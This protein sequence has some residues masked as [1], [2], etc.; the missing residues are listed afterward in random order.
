MTIEPIDNV[1][2][3]DLGDEVIILDPN[4][5]SFNDATLDKFNENLSL[6]YDYFSSKS[7][8]A[9]SIQ[10]I[11][12]MDY[13]TIYFTKFAEAKAEGI[14]DKGADAMAKVSPTVIEANKSAINAKYN[15]RQIKEYL[16]AYDKTHDMAKARQYQ[17]GKE[18]D[19]FGS[20][21]YYKKE[22]NVDDILSSND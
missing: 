7:A 10:A 21:N 5:L 16:K 19:K 1:R 12:E 17:R 20:D 6:Y 4:L 22:I 15:N 14:S 9:E 3:V 8:K 11:A 2:N 18:A 13:D